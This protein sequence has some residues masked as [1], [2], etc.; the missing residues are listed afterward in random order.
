MSF[1]DQIDRQQWVGRFEGIESA[2]QQQAA[3]ISS[4]AA[5]YYFDL[6]QPIN[7]MQSMFTKWLEDTVSL[8][9]GIDGFFNNLF[10]QQENIPDAVMGEAANA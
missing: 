4:F 10:Q 7:T 2:R 3:Y 1:S 9:E 5:G 8:R 6:L